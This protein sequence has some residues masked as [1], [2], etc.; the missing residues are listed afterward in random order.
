MI[1]DS[2]NDIA[3]RFSLL[4]F[5]MADP[6]QDLSVQQPGYGATTFTCFPKLPLELRLMIWRAVFPR[7]RMVEIEAQLNSFDYDGPPVPSTLMINQE[8]RKETLRHYLLYYQDDELLQKVPTEA[9]SLRSTR[10]V[11]NGPR[12]ICYSPGRDLLFLYYWPEHI[13]ATNALLRLVAEKCEPIGEIRVLATSC[14]SYF[15]KWSGGVPDSNPL[16]F[17]IFHDLKEI[18]C[19]I[20]PGLNEPGEEWHKSDVT[21]A[22]GKAFDL[23]REK[24]QS[25]N[26]PKISFFDS[27]PDFKRNMRSLDW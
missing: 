22:V 4:T 13:S 10:N 3:E 8:S 7:G 1:L 12:P 20:E 14:F 26:K 19:V 9:S 17:T 18:C 21:E 24:C 11:H 5:E 6:E 15:P 25:H 23:Q 2:P 16:G 27:L